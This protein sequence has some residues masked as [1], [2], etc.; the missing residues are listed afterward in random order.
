MRT[1]IDAV[2]GVFDKR[3]DL[4]RGLGAAACQRADFTR[5]DRKTTALLARARRFHRRVERE[6]V[7]LER[8]AVDDVSYLRN[9]VRAGGDFVHGANDAIHHVP[10]FQRGFRRGTRQL[11]RLTGVIGVLL[12]RRGQLLHA[13]GGLFQR[14]G[15]LLGTRGEIVA[16][17]GDFARAGKDGIGAVA[18]GTDRTGQRLLHLVDVARQQRHFVMAL[19]ID[20][21]RQI[22]CGNRADM[23]HHVMQRQQQHTAHRHPADDNDSEHHHHNR[24]EDPQNAL[25]VAFVV[26]HTFAG[27]LRLLGAPFAIDFLHVVLLLLGVLLEHPFQIAFGQEFIHLRQR[28]GVDAVLLFE[29]VNQTLVHARRFRQFKV[30]IVVAL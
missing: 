2:A 20:R 9:L 15:L 13:G 8:D 3:F 18:H 24:G 27:K 5:D 6:D 28:R 7:G 29:T 16:A 14:R 30:R 19:R 4:F 23:A 21:L 25:V 10:A 12:H 26:L 1:R 22:A 11:R 17:G